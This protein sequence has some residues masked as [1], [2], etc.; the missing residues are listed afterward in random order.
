MG[1]FS[2]EKNWLLS[3]LRASDQLAAPFL[4][5]SRQPLQG[6]S[7]HTGTH[8][9]FQPS[10]RPRHPTQGEQVVLNYTLHAFMPLAFS[11]SFLKMLT[12]AMS[13]SDSKPYGHHLAQVS[14][15]FI[16]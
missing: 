11:L 2:L 3:R 1:R 6:C 13:I 16:Q 8:C 9:L 12:S 7:A 5:V 10:L 15:S 14:F 4:L